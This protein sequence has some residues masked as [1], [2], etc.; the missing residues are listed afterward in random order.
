NRCEYS[1]RSALRCGL[2][3]PQPSPNSGEGVFFIF[4]FAENF[5]HSRSKSS[6]DLGEDLGGVELQLTTKRCSRKSATMLKYEIHNLP[7]LKINRQ[8]LRKNQTSAEEMLWQLLRKE[9]L[10]GRKFRRQ[11]S[12]ENYIVDFYCASEMLII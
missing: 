8:E 4:S 5:T 1:G 11:H 10:L 2:T 7:H 12:I 9:Q 6:P 3:P